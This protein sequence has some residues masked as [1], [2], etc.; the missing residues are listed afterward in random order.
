MKLD[1]VTLDSDGRLPS[2]AEPGGYPMVY[3][4]AGPDGT[5]YLC[6]DCANVPDNGASEA[7]IYYEGPEALDEW[8]RKGGHLPTA[9]KPMKGRR[10]REPYHRVEGDVIEW[11]PLGPAPCDVLIRQDDGSETW[12]GSSGCVPLD[13]AGP[14]PGRAE[15][16]RAAAA[17]T[18]RSLAAIADRWSRP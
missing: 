7:A 18:S 5:E 8:M 11:R 14:L 6:P 1:D 13:G 12:V 10:I 4:A 9:W 2:Y 3:F 15:A 16:Q 17:E